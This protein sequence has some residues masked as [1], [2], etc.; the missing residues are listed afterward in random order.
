MTQAA[1]RKFYWGFLFIMID[2]RLNGIDIL[3]DIIGYALFVAGLGWLREKN[4]YFDRARIFHIIML[5]L[6]IFSIYEKPSQNME[7]ISFNPL[8]T[9]LGV[10]SLIFSLLAM[11][12]FL[13]GVKQFAEETNV[14]DISDEA[15]LRW[16]Q[17]LYLQLASFAAFLLILLPPL[18][19]VYIIALLVVSVILTVKFMGFMT[20]CG[21]RLQD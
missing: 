17:Y 16:K 15:Q 7:S 21:F 20:R 1:F 18:A 11:H 3:P 5:I 8:G 19:F 2:F 13:W 12:H 6:S 14:P 10:L 9:L 4:Y